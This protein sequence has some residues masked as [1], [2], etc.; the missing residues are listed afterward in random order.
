MGNDTDFDAGLSPALIAAREHTRMVAKWGAVHVDGMDQ[1]RA[2]AIGLQPLVKKIGYATNTQELPRCLRSEGDAARYIRRTA[3]L[4]LQNCVVWKEIEINCRE[5][6]AYYKEQLT[7][8]RVHEEAYRTAAEILAKI[9]ARLGLLKVWELSCPGLLQSKTREL[10]L[11][12]AGGQEG[13]P[14]YLETLKEKMRIDIVYDAVAYLKKI[15]DDRP[16]RVTDVELKQAAVALLA[17]E[18]QDKI[19]LQEAQLAQVGEMWGR[20][21]GDTGEMGGR[22]RTAREIDRSICPPTHRPP[23]LHQP[24]RSSRTLAMAVTRFSTS[25]ASCRSRCRPTCSTCSHS[26]CWASRSSSSR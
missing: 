13:T 23:T 20:Y 17:K 25:I 19:M 18:Q 21:G 22:T 6:N 11:Q 2:E 1:H 5:T 26:S 15:E 14:V 3:E 9:M 10:E 7:V 8:A 4:L 16:I 24:I 12:V